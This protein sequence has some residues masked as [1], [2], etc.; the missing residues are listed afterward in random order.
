MLLSPPLYALSWSTIYL[1]VINFHLSIVDKC[2][3]LVTFAAATFMVSLVIA[4]FR[5]V[6][7]MNL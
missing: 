4:I 6:N 1:A 7:P 3:R 2:N 5:E